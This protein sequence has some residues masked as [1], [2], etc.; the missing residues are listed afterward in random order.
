MPQDV[1]ESW[2]SKADQLQFIGQAEIY[3]ALVARITWKE[4]LRGRHAI[5]YIDNESARISLVRQYSPVLASLGI[6]VQCTRFDMA[7]LIDPWYSRV[8]THSNPADEPS[9]LSDDELVGRGS[10]RV[11]GLL[12]DGRRINF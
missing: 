1:V 4:R 5:F 10:V 9:R 8:P 12:P 3:P 11:D 2:A 6:L 7:H